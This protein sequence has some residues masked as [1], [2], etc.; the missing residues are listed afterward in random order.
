MKESI[1]SKRKIL[2]YDISQ[3]CGIFL[4]IIPAF[5]CLTAEY[6]SGSRF[7]EI[8]ENIRPHPE[9]I[10]YAVTLYFALIIRYQFFRKDTLG[11]VCFSSIQ[12]I[13]N[14]WVLASICQVTLISNVSSKV[15]LIA[16]LLS[17]LGMHTV[18]GYSWIIFIV[19]AF[20]S[21]QSKSPYMGSDIR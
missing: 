1:L 14:I 2:G 20:W 15:L 10:L 6:D 7:R 19:A 21:M 17:W 5:I 13:L 18:A 16:V 12:M 3:F 11:E 9:A 8:I 4:M